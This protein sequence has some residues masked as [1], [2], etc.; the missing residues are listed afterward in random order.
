MARPL[1]NGLDYFPLDT[2]FLQDVKI[3]KLL[4]NFEGGKGVSVYI[5]LL[6]RIY[7]EWYFITWDKNWRFNISYD[8]KFTEEFV[9]KCVDFMVEIGLFDKRLYTTKNI[10]TSHGIQKQYF[11]IFR[12]NKRKTPSSFPYL[13]IEFPQEE[14]PNSCKKQQK[15]FPQEETQFP[16]EESTQSKVKKRKDNLPSVDYQRLRTRKTV[17]I[18]VS[19]SDEKVFSGVDEEVSELL[20]QNAWKNAVFE[21]FGFLQGNEEFLEGFL[22]RWAQEVKISSKQHINLGDAKNHFAKW[23]IIQEEK[24]IKTKNN[25]KENNNGYRTDEDIIRGAIN[26]YK[27][28]RAENPEPSKTLPVA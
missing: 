18:S 3:K 19:Q 23:M 28:L 20:N 12:L 16:Q 2:N 17:E 10:L 22:L 1:K 7:S 27:E 11:L 5:Y 14:T 4:L 15:S 13:L 24:F 26:I 9:Q 25:G 8:L 21:R 6:A